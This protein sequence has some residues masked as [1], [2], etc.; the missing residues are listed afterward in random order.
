MLAVP[1][2]HALL[3]RADLMAMATCEFAAL[4]MPP[5]SHQTRAIPIK[6]AN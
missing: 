6:V 5:L 2:L 4:T 1:H 3:S